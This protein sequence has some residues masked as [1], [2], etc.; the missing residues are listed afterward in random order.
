MT[1]KNFEPSQSSNALLS[2]LRSSERPDQDIFVELQ[3]EIKQIA[4][5]KMRRERLDHTLQPSALVNEAYIKVL[6]NSLPANVLSDPAQMCRLIAHVMDQILKD[7]ADAHNAKKRGGSSKRRVPLDE[8]QAREFNDGD[9]VV[10][11]IASQLWLAP[12]QA[13][14]ILAVR[15]ALA[16]LRK[17]SPREAEVLTLTFYGGLTREEI[18]ALL[19]VS[20][21][22]VKL[23]AKKGKAFLSV[24]LRNKAS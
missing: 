10:P 18:A 24:F 21:E 14:H 23:D 7:Y 11:A 2:N 3:H 17:H 20:P 5:A 6:K 9:S 22:T 8:R 4:M 15:E 16:S 1:I 19:G 12:A 13:E